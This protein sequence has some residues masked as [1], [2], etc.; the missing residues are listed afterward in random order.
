M[1]LKGFIDG[2]YVSIKGDYFSRGPEFAILRS[3]WLEE[4]GTAPEGARVA[5]QGARVMNPD[6]K[7]AA[8][9]GTGPRGSTKGYLHLQIRKLKGH[10]R[11]V[12]NTEHLLEPKEQ[13]LDLT[14]FCSQ[15]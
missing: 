12:S 14:V 4:E 10:E 8:E 11:G 5:N 3:Q 2:D 1:K 6:C 13:P 15:I 7:G 9:L